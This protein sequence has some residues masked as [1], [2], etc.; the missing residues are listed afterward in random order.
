M[1]VSYCIYLVYHVGLVISGRGKK[2]VC[3]PGFSIRAAAVLNLLWLGRSR[4]F[5]NEWAQDIPQRAAGYGQ[6]SGVR[7]EK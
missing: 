3:D 5:M 7:G 4:F 1:C 2:S 6:L